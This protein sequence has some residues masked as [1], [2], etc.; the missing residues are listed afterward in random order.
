MVRS[1]RGGV[2]PSIRRHCTRDPR[3]SLGHGSRRAPCLGRGRPTVSSEQRWQ[4][5]GWGWRARI[6]VIVPH[7][8]LVPDAE[9]SAM[10]PAG[11]GIHSTRVFFGPMASDPS[12]TE[13]IELAGLR[14]YLRPPLLDDAAALLAGA[15]VSVIAYAFTSTSYLGDDGDDDVLK[16]RLQRRTDG[17]PV[18]T[19]CAAA[20]QAL[21]SL[22]VDRIALVHPPWISGELNDMGAS[23]FRRR[24][25]DVVSASS[26][27]RLAGLS[28]STPDDLRRIAESVENH[29]EEAVALVLGQRRV[30]AHGA[31][32]L[33]ELRAVDVG[34]DHARFLGAADDAVHRVVDTLLRTQLE[35][36]VFVEG[37]AQFVEERALALRVPRERPE[38]RHDR[39]PRV[40]LCDHLIC[41]RYQLVDIVAIDGLHYIDALRK[42]AVQ[43]ADADA[44]FAGNGL[45]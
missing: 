10:A 9:L 23:F 22:D 13:P 37:L 38:E 5:D 19:T 33:H 1:P 24:G 27:A 30:N 12:S 39:R 11:V 15:P 7:A 6:G 28:A 36:G 25:I 20:V 3:S 21:R 14:A 41:S 44:R 17:I 29:V 2:R 16:D 8:D 4:P 18:V 26:I 45:H 35:I 34:A 42:V 32:E 31:D 40:E 43:R